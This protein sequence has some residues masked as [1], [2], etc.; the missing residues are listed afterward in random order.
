[1]TEP[2]IICQ[3]CKTEIKLAESLAVPFIEFIYRTYGKR[4]NKN[5]ADIANFDT[6]WGQ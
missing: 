4:L 5:N 2:T 1:M 3:T 6:F